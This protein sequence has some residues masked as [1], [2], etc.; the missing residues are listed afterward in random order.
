MHWNIVSMLL[1]ATYFS[2]TPLSAQ[3][4]PPQPAEW[5][6]WIVDKHSDSAVIVVAGSLAAGWHI[7]AQQEPENGPIPLRIAIDDPR[8]AEIRG[9]LGGSAPTRRQ[10]PSFQLLTE[11]YLSDFTLRVPIHLKEAAGGAIPLAI[12]YQ[13]CND[14]TCLPPRTVHLSVSARVEK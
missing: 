12:R 7:Y 4:F 1:L 14:H 3:N 8:V 6:T 5:K 2:A 10:D 9:K 13:A 11:V